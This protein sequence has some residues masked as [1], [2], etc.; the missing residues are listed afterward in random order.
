MS[1]HLQGLQCAPK[2]A[3]DMVVGLAVSIWSTAYLSLEQLLGMCRH[4]A[5]A[6]G[7]GLWPP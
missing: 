6:A 5:A 1:Y 3:T 7:R 2:V 4:R